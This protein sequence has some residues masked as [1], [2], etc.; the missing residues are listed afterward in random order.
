MRYDDGNR[1]D[2]QP[3]MRYLRYCR[4][5]RLLVHFRNN[6]LVWGDAQPERSRAALLHRKPTVLREM[7]ALTQ[8][9]ERVPRFGGAQQLSW[10]DLVSCLS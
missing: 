6:C 4:R 5:H 9:K 1:N 8:S 3:L 7:A 10:R 2:L